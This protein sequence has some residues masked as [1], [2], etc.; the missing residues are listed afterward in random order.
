MADIRPDRLTTCQSE[1]NSVVNRRPMY[2]SRDSECDPNPHYKFFFFNYISELCF[3]N[4][5]YSFFEDINNICCDATKENNHI[6]GKHGYFYLFDN[7]L[8]SEAL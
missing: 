7:I 3:R 1:R 8:Y 2:C 6:P 4:L 5:C